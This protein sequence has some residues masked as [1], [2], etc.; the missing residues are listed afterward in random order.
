MKKLILLTIIA[1]PGVIFV[2]A[3]V[4]FQNLASMN[5]ARSL[6]SCATD[7]NNI[8]VCYGLT[9][10]TGY[11]NE[12]EKYNILTNNWT[13]FTNSAV[14]KRFTS[15]EIIGDKLYIFNGLTGSSVY[16]NKMEVVNLLTGV[17]T[18]TVD[19]PFPVYSSGSLVWNN[20]IYF[21]GGS[22]S[23]GYSNKI[24]V[25]DPILINWSELASMPEAKETKG[26]IIDGK[27]YVIGGYNGDSSN[28]IDMYDIQNNTW[29]FVMSMPLGISA[30]YTAAWN[31]KIW[32]VGDY[33]NVTSLAYYDVSTNQ[34]SF[35]QSNLI[36]GRHRGA[37]AVDGKLYVAGGNQTSSASSCIDNLQVTT[38]LS[39]IIENNLTSLSIYPNLV[40]D[41]LTIETLQN[42]T[43]KIINMEGQL[44]KTIEAKNEQTNV[45][46]SALPSGVYVVKVK[47]E[48]EWGLVSLLNSKKF[49]L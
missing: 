31:N 4:N 25:F 14:G 41:N 38:N 42:A 30:H 46:I 29:S 32:I 15:A 11:S 44:I 9:P 6:I 24:Y 12:I 26:E 36:G 34:F 19:N 5:S 49:R 17:I 39:V 37:V 21:F 10:A 23:S 33:V 35:V 18:Y 1:L 43:I 8:Y 13:V 3:Q 7:G 16:N 22:S 47:T 48:K 28:R 40:I 27:L 20:K 45:D 2:N